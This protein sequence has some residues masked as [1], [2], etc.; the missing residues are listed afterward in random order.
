MKA[1]RSSP[2][3]TGMSPAS[4]WRAIS[5]IR[6]SPGAPWTTSGHAIRV[7]QGRHH[8]QGND[9]RRRARKSRPQKQLERAEAALADGEQFGGAV[10]ASSPGIRAQRDRARPR[11]YSL[12]HQ[13]RRIGAMIIGRN[14]LV[15]INANIVTQPSPRRSRR[16]S[17][18]W[19]GAIRWGADTVM[20][21]PPAAISTTRANGSCAIRR[22]RS[23]PS[24]LPGAG[25]GG[26]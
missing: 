5:P 21:L 15:K 22:C 13:P 25:E 7:R 10:P 2:S 11:D 18:R 4:T 23:A 6:R 19:C 8:H 1:G 26:R 3:T 16:K 24:D 20:D 12:Q 14:F 17:R 9:L